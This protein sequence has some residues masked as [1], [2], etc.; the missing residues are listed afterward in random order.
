MRFRVACFAAAISGC[1]ASVNIAQAATIFSDFG[2]G[3]AFDHSF[4]W[5]VS[6]PASSSG[7][8]FTPA[9]PFTSVVNADVT[10]IDIAMAN[11]VLDSSTV[12]SATLKLFVNTGGAF[13]TLLGTFS[14]NNILNINGGG[15]T[16]LSVTG[17]SGVHLNAG[18][19]YYL[20]ASASGDTDDGGWYVNSIGV[21]GTLLILRSDDPGHNI[22]QD[23]TLGAFAIIGDVTT[24]TVPLPGAL[25]LFVSGLGALG[26]LGW[27]RKK[28][29]A[30][31]AA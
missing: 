9:M 16:V 14:V 11:H 10:Q 2:A 29:A 24:P 3:N 8:A 7:I 25:P 4:S 28:K 5:I 26:L 12:T 18:G 27:R 20:Q 6:G 30:A 22:L 17:I 1:L 13:G 31:L 23:G 19:N 15:P 21:T